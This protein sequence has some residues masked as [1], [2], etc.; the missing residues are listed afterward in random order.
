[1]AKNQINL[2]NFIPGGRRGCRYAA[3]LTKQALRLN[4]PGDKN[5]TN[6]RQARGFGEMETVDNN[7]KMWGVETAR[8]AS[9]SPC[10]VERYHCWRSSTLQSEERPRTK[11][12]QENPSFAY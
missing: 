5:R 6:K 4:P 10:V 3:I 7:G 11:S 9:L 12:G 2:I 8:N 1:M